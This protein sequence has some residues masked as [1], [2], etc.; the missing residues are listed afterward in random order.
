MRE[1]YE[2]IGCQVRPLGNKVL[3]LEGPSNVTLPD[4]YLERYW[5]PSQGR[6]GL[7]IYEVIDITSLSVSEPSRPNKRYL[8]IPCRL[9]GHPKTTHAALEI[10]YM[11]PSE[12]LELKLKGTIKLMP[13]TSIVLALLELGVFR[14]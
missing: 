14:I 13:T 6:F 5:P 9:V 8:Y 3:M 1:C 7:H 12:A 10:T 2:E 4:D 11:T